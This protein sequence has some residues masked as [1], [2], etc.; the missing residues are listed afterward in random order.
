M[1]IYSEYKSYQEYVDIQTET[2]KEKIEVVWVM[3]EEVIQ[4]S[5]YI[6]L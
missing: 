1:K 4:L 5:N 3:Q 2:N 6:S